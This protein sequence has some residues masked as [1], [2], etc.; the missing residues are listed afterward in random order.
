LALERYR[1]S[2]S[3][4]LPGAASVFR[5]HCGDAYGSERA[6]FGKLFTCF[7][8]HFTLTRKRPTSTKVTRLDLVVL[9]TV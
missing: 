6:I 9:P 7:R 5:R 3:L 2:S 4:A 1:P 8:N